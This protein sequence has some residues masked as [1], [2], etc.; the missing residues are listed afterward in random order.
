MGVYPKEGEHEPEQVKVWAEKQC[1]MGV[2][3]RGYQ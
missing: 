2:K 3:L 1:D